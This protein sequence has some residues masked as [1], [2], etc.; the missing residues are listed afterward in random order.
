M[1]AQ[2]IALIA[3]KA[4]EAKQRMLTQDINAAEELV[5]EVDIK[6]TSEIKQM[7]G[8]IEGAQ[9]DLR[10]QLTALI[11]KTDAA[12]KAMRAN[13]QKL[14]TE[15][16]GSRAEARNLCNEFAQANESCHQ[17]MLTRLQAT[18]D[19]SSKTDANLEAGRQELTSASENFAARMAGLEDRLT[20][21][22]SVAV[23]SQQG[24]DSLRHLVEEL[25]VCVMQIRNE[26]KPL[27]LGQKVSA[28]F[29]NVRA[30]FLRRHELRGA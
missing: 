17:A 4:M 10:K 30:W 2:A 11:E 9:A 26:P 18:E 21:M 8:Q 13:R 15:L 25:S 20:H 7:G 16:E 19:A 28:L 23:S 12:D 22:N 5:R 3:D 27:T 29:A 6:L 24:I 1:I 14:E